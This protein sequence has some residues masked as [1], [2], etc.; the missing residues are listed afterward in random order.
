MIDSAVLVLEEKKIQ[1][2][3]QI[4]KN[5]LGNVVKHITVIPRDATNQ[6]L[7]EDIPTSTLFQISF[8][9]HNLCIY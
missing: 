3:T 1:Y 7:I 9:I 8:K 5:E 2:F 4:I 6:E